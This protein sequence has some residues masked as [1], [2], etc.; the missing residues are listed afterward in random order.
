MD[1]MTYERGAIV[2]HFDKCGLSSP[3]TGEALPSALLIENIT[4]RRALAFLPNS[5]QGPQDSGDSARELCPIMNLPVEILL[6][7]FSFLDGFELAR[8]AT[9]CTEWRAIV[10]DD[11]LWDVCLMNEF[12]GHTAPNPFQALTLGARGREGDENSS[13]PTTSSR[14]KYRDLF[15]QL[16]RSKAP[17]QFTRPPRLPGVK[18]FSNNRGRRRL[19]QLPMK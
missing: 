19:P 4:V 18:L 3:S 9:V 11:F 17:G 7:I 2:A 10:S 6:Y 1:G 12:P 16:V 14:V 5:S 8:C 13:Q 15:I